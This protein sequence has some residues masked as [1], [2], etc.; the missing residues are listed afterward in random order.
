MFPRSR[1][2]LCEST[3]YVE[4]R[5][6]LVTPLQQCILTFQPCR[7]LRTACRSERHSILGTPHGVYTVRRG[8]RAVFRLAF[9]FRRGSYKRVIIRLP[10]TLCPHR[11]FV[12]TLSGRQHA[13]TRAVVSRRRLT[14]AGVCSPCALSVLKHRVYLSA[15]RFVMSACVCNA[16]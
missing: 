5:V 16:C 7:Q 4:R 2:R 1:M 13:P 14:R 12:V 9:E 15:G 10:L 6:C 11:L 8:A 3:R